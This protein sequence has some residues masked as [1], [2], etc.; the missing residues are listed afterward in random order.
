MK[1]RGVSPVIATVLLIGIVIALALMVFMW[2][3]AFVKETITKFDGQNIE[4]VCDEVNIQADY[5]GGQLAISNIGNVPIY[6]V[7]IR[8]SNAA[9]FS[10]ENARDISTW[11]KYGLNPGG[12]F[13]GGASL[14]GDITLIPI[15]IGNSE[16]GQRVFACDEER[17]GYI[18]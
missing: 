6:D 10:N 1:K 18:L 16:K 4:L 3:S 2:M 11:P 15:L 17:N 7:R 8:K 9:G 14:E 12:A 13:S 5:S